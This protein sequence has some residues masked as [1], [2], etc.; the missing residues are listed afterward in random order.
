MS[1]LT[2]NIL[3]LDLGNLTHGIQAEASGFYQLWPH[4][5]PRYDR[6]SNF[7]LRTHQNI[8]LSTGLA[9]YCASLFL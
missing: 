4:P 5:V 6:D 9:G 3:K 8:S 7:R 2:L 1:G